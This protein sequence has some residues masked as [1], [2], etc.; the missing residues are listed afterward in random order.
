MLGRGLEATRNMSLFEQDMPVG[1]DMHCPLAESGGYRSAVPD[2]L[3][4]AVTNDPE[5]WTVMC[6]R[7]R[8]SKVAWGLG[9]HPC[10]LIRGDE[11]LATMIKAMGDASAIGEVGLDY[12]QKARCGPTEQ[13][14][15]LDKI[16]SQPEARDRVVTLHSVGA[17]KDI[18]AAVTDHDIRGAVLHWFLGSTAEVDAAVAADVYFS[19]NISM[20]RSPRGRNAINEMPPNRVLVETDA[21]FT[22]AGKLA[23]RPGDVASIERSLAGIWKIDLLEVRRRLWS[24]LEALQSRLKV[25]LFPYGSPS[26]DKR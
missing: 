8:E 3:L 22:K 18:V 16:F 6:R 5:T 15:A 14:T 25:V 21:P 9:L 7:S 4:L 13:R 26:L 19:V 24:N 20:V 10:D 2:T 23:T 11:R 12:S 1:V 17:T